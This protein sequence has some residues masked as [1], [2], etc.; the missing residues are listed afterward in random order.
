MR[1]GKG[2]HH[3]LSPGARAFS[4]LA[5]LLAGCATEP[6]E[7]G[8]RAA[9]WQREDVTA[10]E[11][12]PLAPLALPVPKPVPAPPAPAA[13]T[14]QPTETWVP[15]SRWC[16]ANGLAAPCPLTV[17]ALPAYMLSTP[18]G[19]FVFR[20]GSESGRWDGLEL[21]LGFAPQMMGGQPC[22]H[23][24]DLKKTL[25]PLATGAPTS[26]L[27]TNPTIVIDPGHGG[28]D[29]GT[30]SVAGYGY[31][32]DFTLD[33][34]RRLGF[35]L[36]TNGWRVFLT[37]TTDTDL[38]LSNRVAIA[39]ARKADLFLSLHFNSA[40][41]NEREAGLETYCLTPTGLPSSV[42]RGYGDDP[43]L[44]FPNNTFDAQNLQL[45]LRVHRELLQVN[46][47]LDR[48][49]RRARYLGVLRGQHRPAVLIEGGYLSN[50]REA[51]LIAAPAYRQKLAEAVALAL[52]GKSEVQSR[53]PRIGG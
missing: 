20:P 32:K 9:D 29:S 6:R 34:A 24:L 11:A 30:K 49:V 2:R 13:A 22:I 23:T 36:A 42:T 5:V 21:R 51:R 40:A 15:L 33:W 28:M 27:K 50:P 37:R 25:E 26:C 52:A 18:N 17:A 47:R 8:E 38:S 3:G 10:T 35:L 44:T 1:S 12:A 41:P 7:S 53:E 14:N 4:L 46:G 39:E 19:V 45:A 43:A 48:G 16:K 31:E